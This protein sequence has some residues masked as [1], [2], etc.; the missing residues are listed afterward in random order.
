MKKIINGIETSLTQEEILLKQQQDA[1]W[2]NGAFDRAIKELR[3]TR[4]NLLSN[5][6]FYVIKAKENNEEV[7]ANI[8]TYRQEL[9]DLTEGLTTVEQVNNILI[10]KLFPTK[11]E[12]I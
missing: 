12:Q 8:K 5:T 4:N 3:N 7:P 2:N 11:P 1:E 10:N 9:R 6:D